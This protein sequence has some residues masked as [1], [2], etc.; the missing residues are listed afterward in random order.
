[1][2]FLVASCCSW[3]NNLI[4]WILCFISYISFL[5][6]ESVGLGEAQTLQ[7]EIWQKRSLVST[8]QMMSV[9]RLHGEGQQV[10][11]LME[12]P[13]KRPYLKKEDGK[14]WRTSDFSRAPRN[15][16]RYH[17]VPCHSTEVC[18]IKTYFLLWLKMV[19][20]IWIVAVSSVFLVAWKMPFVKCFETYFLYQTLIF[21]K[22]QQM[23]KRQAS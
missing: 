13:W 14:D 5:L 9:K 7:S 12:V 4:E 20:V 17:P 6:V 2:A 11:G 15:T 10:G 3:V 21:I 19:L 1:M 8:E 23:E 18:L 22:I 16:E